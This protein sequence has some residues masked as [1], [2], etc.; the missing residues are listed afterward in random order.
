M[1]GLRA[2]PAVTTTISEPLI[3]SNRSLP[4]TNASTDRI[5]S[6]SVMSVAF[7]TA[8][9]GAISIRKTDAPVFQLSLQP[10]ALPHFQL[11]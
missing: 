7:A 5:E 8:S 11:L 3:S 1:P 6:E 9:L 4:L 10:Q 2:S